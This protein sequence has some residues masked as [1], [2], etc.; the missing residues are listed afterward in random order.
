[1]G[2]SDEMSLGNP[3]VSPPEKKPKIYNSSE[4]AESSVSLE[5][6]MTLSGI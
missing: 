3:N 1:M 4:L 2:I 6:H 5:K